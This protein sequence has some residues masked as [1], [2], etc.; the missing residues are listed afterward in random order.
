MVS[1]VTYSSTFLP[2]PL[3]DDLGWMFNVLLSGSVA[4]AGTI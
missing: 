2:A 3:I 1:S 4:I